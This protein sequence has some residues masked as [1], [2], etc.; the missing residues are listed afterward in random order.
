MIFALL[1]NL[2][3]DSASRMCPRRSC[4]E[5]DPVELAGPDQ[6]TDSLVQPLA[7]PGD[8]IAGYA[9]RGF[10]HDRRILLSLLTLRAWPIHDENI[11]RKYNNRANFWRQR[12]VRP[13]VSGAHPEPYGSGND[14]NPGR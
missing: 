7:A 8:K 12:V 5:K 6:F 4:F 11:D 1:P 14:V 9:I 2:A 3:D 10:R 13:R